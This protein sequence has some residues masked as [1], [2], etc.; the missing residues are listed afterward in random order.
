MSYGKHLCLLLDLFVIG[1]SVLVVVEYGALARK[2]EDP[3]LFHS[4]RITRAVTLAIRATKLTT[5]NDTNASSMPS[6]PPIGAPLCWVILAPGAAQRSNLGEIGNGLAAVGCGGSWRLWH[7]RTP[8]NNGDP[9]ISSTDRRWKAR[10]GRNCIHVIYCS[11]N[12]HMISCGDGLPASEYRPDHLRLRRGACR[13]RGVELRL[14]L[15][16]SA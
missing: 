8:G 2:D 16:G 10:T 7:R 15:R 3:I 6:M 11:R 13:Q 9:A 12:E 4:Y 14:S 5:A 1:A